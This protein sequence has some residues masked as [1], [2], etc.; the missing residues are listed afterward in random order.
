MQMLL[1]V[2]CN[3]HNSLPQQLIQKHQVFNPLGMIEHSSLI[4]ALIEMELIDTSPKI[5]PGVSPLDLPV[6]LAKM[7]RNGG[8]QAA[9]DVVQ[10]LLFSAHILG[11]VPPETVLLVDQL[12]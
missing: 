1:Q 8:M 4:L 12:P 10:D 2:G 9:N 11:V 6:K 5:G 7:G 3:L